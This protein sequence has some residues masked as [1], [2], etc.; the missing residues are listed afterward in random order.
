MAAH[1]VREGRGP[2]PP[3]APAPPERSATS[4]YLLRVQV[5]LLSKTDGPE[6]FKGLRP[7]IILPVGENIVSKI[8]LQIAEPCDR[9]NNP[10]AIADPGVLG[11]RKVASAAS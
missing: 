7:I 9:A 8:V 4:R 5:R 10:Q 6:E 11:F 1:P 2:E 3:S